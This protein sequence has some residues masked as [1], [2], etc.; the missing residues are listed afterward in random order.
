MLTNRMLKVMVRSIYYCLYA[1]FGDNLHRLSC[2]WNNGS[3]E[4]NKKPVHKQHEK[5]G[6]SLLANQRSG[7]IRNGSN[8]WI[9]F[10]SY[11]TTDLRITVLNFVKDE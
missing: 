5:F 11:G 10:Q 2:V 1:A 8:E 4:E 9:D 3:S 6:Y 7:N